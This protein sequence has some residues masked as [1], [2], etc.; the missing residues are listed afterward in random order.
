MLWKKRDELITI[1]TEQ[2]YS[3]VTLIITTL[4]INSN[5]NNN[6]IAIL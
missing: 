2:F 3:I 6:K 5:N 1:A 4:S